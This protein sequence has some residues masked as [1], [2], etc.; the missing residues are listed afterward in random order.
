MIRHVWGSG[1]KPGIH[2]FTIKDNYK[3]GKEAIKLAKTKVAIASG[4][5]DQLTTGMEHLLDMLIGKEKLVDMESG[6]KETED[7]MRQLE[8]IEEGF[9]DFSNVLTQWNNEKVNKVES[10]LK[11]S[12]YGLSNN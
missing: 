4:C 7:V 6:K 8:K 3:T 12:G 9:A 10:M 11:S 1:R 5:V 2:V